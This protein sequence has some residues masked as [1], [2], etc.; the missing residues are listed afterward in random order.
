MEKQFGMGTGPKPIILFSL[1]MFVD[2]R[3]GRGGEGLV[4]GCGNKGGRSCGVLCSFHILSRSRILGKEGL[5]F[6]LYTEL[7]IFTPS[8]PVCNVLQLKISAN[9]H[10]KKKNKKKNKKKG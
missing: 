10:K 7:C 1:F 2:P 6:H 3:G 4:P 8:P 5:I 9:I